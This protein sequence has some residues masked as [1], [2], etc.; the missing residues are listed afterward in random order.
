M[1]L[2]EF[3]Q[4]PG[5]T[6]LDNGEYVEGVSFDRPSEGWGS[7]FL[8]L[9]KRSGMAISI[10]SVAVF[11]ALGADGFISTARVALGSVAPV[12]VRSHNAEGALTGKIPTLEIFRSAGK[13]ALKDISPIDDLRASAEYR[14]HAVSVLIE[15][16][17]SIAWERAESRQS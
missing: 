3:F 15:R 9:G 2:A 13:A 8:K 14:A 4:G 5:Q 10:V 11:L 7:T 1:P 17:L 12:P 6:A 16:A